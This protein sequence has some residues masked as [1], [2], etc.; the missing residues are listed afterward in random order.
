MQAL[1][2]NFVVFPLN[3][4][5]QKGYKESWAK[6]TFPLMSRTNTA[7]IDI[8]NLNSLYLTKKTLKYTIASKTKAYGAV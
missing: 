4:S 6:L 5:V 7:D 1:L 3:I 2:Q 8:L